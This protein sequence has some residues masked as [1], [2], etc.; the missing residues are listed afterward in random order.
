MAIVDLRPGEVFASRYVAER[1][2]GTGGMGSVFA[3]NDVRSGRRLA[4][5]LLLPTLVSD[6]AQRERFLREAQVRERLGSSPHIAEVLEVGVEPSTSTPFVLM[7]LLEGR[8]LSA[9]LAARGPLPVAEVLALLA[10]LADALTVAHAAGVVHRDLKPENLFVVE[11]PGAAPVLKVLDFGIAKLIQGA[12]ATATAT[13]G[14]PLYMAPEQGKRGARVGP[15]ADLMA[16]GLIAYRLL[17][18]RSYWYGDDAPTLYGELFS[19]SY[20]PACDRAAEQGVPLPP[21]FDSFFARTV[22]PASDDRVSSAREAFALLE[23]A[24]S[25][26]LSFARAPT[27]VGAPAPPVAPGRTAAGQTAS[28]GGPFAVRG[29]TEVPRPHI[30]PAP[31]RPPQATPTWPFAVAAVALVVGGAGLVAGL[32]QRESRADRDRQ[33][34]RTP[35]RAPEPPEPTPTQATPRKPERRK[36]EPQRETPTPA[37]VP[38]P[39][40]NDSPPEPVRPSLPPPPPALSACQSGMVEVPGGVAELGKSGLGATANEIHTSF[41]STFCIDRTE[42]T[43]SAYERCVAQGP[44]S[45]AAT[46][47]EIRFPEWCNATEPS[48]G[49]HPA[50]CVHA[51]QADAYCRWVGK[52]LPTDEEWEYAARGAHGHTFPWGS[53]SPG[54]NACWDRQGTCVVGSLLSGASP[55]GALDMVGNVYEWTSNAY[56]EPYNGIPK[57]GTRVYRGGAWSTQPA[58]IGNLEPAR[59]AYANELFLSADIGFRCAK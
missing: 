10:Q 3:V 13:G 51:R 47:G 16:F 59:R 22:T 58:K 12:S 48:R 32:A 29:A 28:A 45:S 53:E 44:C 25:A 2:V 38:V 35:P 52:R 46:S 39:V 43:A 55:F 21:G 18:G 56:S 7:E 31:G 17:T 8:D 36:P 54:G 49:S 41:V 40:Q 11:R 4:L 37:P 42:V 26:D 14:T 50:N 6:P 27:R 24:C 33:S 30:P 20:Q 19:A 15:R 23:R 57:A 5:K 9:V 1:R 34:E